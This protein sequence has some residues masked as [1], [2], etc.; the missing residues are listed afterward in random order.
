MPW[1]DGHKVVFTLDFFNLGNLINKKWG[2]VAEYGSD[3]RQGTP[4]YK[5]ACGDA[6]GGPVAATS[7]VCASYRISSVSTTMTTPTVNQAAT[8]YSVMAG[9]KYAF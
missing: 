2:V 6:N 5:V 9:L 4:I 7:P 1:F 3:G 8:L